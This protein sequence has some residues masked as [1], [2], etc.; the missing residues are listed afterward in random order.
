[1]SRSNS[2]GRLKLGGGGQVAIDY[3]K[4]SRRNLRSFAEREKSDHE[5]ERMAEIRVDGLP[6]A[7]GRGGL[8]WNRRSSITARQSVEA[9][10][11]AVQ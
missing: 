8:R 1:M 7:V 2:G 5:V 10:H 3:P 11:S 6:T 4:L 9:G